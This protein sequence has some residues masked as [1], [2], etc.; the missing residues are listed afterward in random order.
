MR[1]NISPEQVWIS[2][3]YGV[4]DFLSFSPLELTVDCFP[5]KINDTSIQIRWIN[6]YPE[7]Y[8][9]SVLVDG[10]VIQ[11]NIRNKSDY[12]LSHLN[13]STHYN[14]C[15]VA[16]DRHGQKRANGEDCEDITTA[17]TS[18]HRELIYVCGQW[19]L[20]VLQ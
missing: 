17:V 13:P 19:L 9:F 1:S 2:G 18:A 15:V 6:P 7:C 11:N 20:T 10:M 4:C 14:V 16:R 3:V 8:S 5:G 12:T